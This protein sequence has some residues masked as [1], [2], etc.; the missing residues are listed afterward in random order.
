MQQREC[1]FCTR[2]TWDFDVC[3]TCID[4]I[5]NEM[6]CKVHPHDRTIPYAVVAMVIMGGI[7]LASVLVR[8]YL[9]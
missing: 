9:S 4:Y 8:E 1:V 2:T 7:I 3:D 6:D 5:C